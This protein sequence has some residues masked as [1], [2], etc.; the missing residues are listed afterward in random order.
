MDVSEKL[1][2]SVIR[3]DA[4]NGRFFWK[5]G[6]YLTEYTTLLPRIYIPT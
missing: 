3:V 5:V 2:A 1:A 4:E 6:I